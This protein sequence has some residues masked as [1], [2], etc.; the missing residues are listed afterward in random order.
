MMP[1]VQPRIDPIADQTFREVVRAAG[2]N[3]EDPWISGYA[4]K[5][6]QRMR[7]FLDAYGALKPGSRVLEFGFNV[8]ATSV[9]LAAAGCEVIGIEV[10]ERADRIARANLARYGLAGRVDF[11]VIAPGAA[12]P[13]ADGSFDTIVCNSVLEYVAPDDLSTVPRELERVLRS[14]GRMLVA[15]TSN[16]LWPIEVHS[17]K[18]INYLPRALDRMLPDLPP[19]GITPFYVTR[20]FR[21]CRNIDVVHRSREYAEYRRRTGWSSGKLSVLRLAATVLAP[22]GLAPGMLTPSFSMVMEKI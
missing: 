4:E 15:S 1:D 16:R 20:N 13:F 17:G 6:W 19:R 10:D 11:R 9:V 12:L 3:P 7:H 22:F 5:Q 21:R 14:G 18:A 8:G 2:L